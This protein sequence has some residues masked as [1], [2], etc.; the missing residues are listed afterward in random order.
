VSKDQL[1]LALQ[2]LAILLFLS[3]GVLP[4]ARG[5]YP[6][7]KWARWGAIAIFSSAVVFAL[8]LVLRWALGRN[9]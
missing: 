3:A 6:L 7:A 5:R 8:F 4:L 2:Y 9:Y 1:M